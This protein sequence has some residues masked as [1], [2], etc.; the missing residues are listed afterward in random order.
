MISTKSICSRI[1]VTLAMLLVSFGLFAQN[2]TVK[3]TVTD[4]SGEPI[5]GAGVLVKGTSTGTTTDLDGKYSISVPQNATLVFSALGYDVVELSTKDRAVVNAAL[6]DSSE[7]LSE[8][9]VTAEFGMKRAARSVGSSVQSVKATDITEAGR[10][11]F[12]NALQGKV[13]GMTITSTGGA[14]GASTSVVLRSATSISGNNQPL[15]VVDGVPINNSTL[16]SQ[17]DFAYDDAVSA[18]SMDFSSRGNDINPEDIESM[19]IL[20]G[21]AAAALYGSDASNGAIIIT[22]KKGSAGRGKVTYSNSFRWENAYGLPDVQ[23]KYSNGAYGATNYYYTSRF[24]GLYPSDMKLYNNMQALLQTGFSQQHNLSVEGGTDKVTVRGALG[25]TDYDGIVKTTGLTRTNITLSGRAEVT[26]WLNFDGK[27]EY[28]QS[29]NTKSSKGLYG[30]LYRASRWPLNSDVQNYITPDGAMSRPELYTD[31]DLLNP[32]FDIYKNVNHDD[33]DRFMGSFNM[34]ITPTRHTFIRATAGVDF[35][36][37]EYKVFTHPYYGDP[38]SSSYGNGALNFSKPTYKDTSFDVLAG[39]NNNWGKFNF[40]AQV[41]YH[42]KA[43]DQHILSVYGSKFQVIDFYSISNC[44]PSTIQ[45]RTKTTTR[46]IQAV[47]AQAELG[48]NNM[49]FLT[50]RA[51]NDWSSTLPK[52]NN[53]YFYPAIEGSFV[54][55]ELPFLKNSDAISYLKLRGAIAQVGKDATPLSIYPSLEATEDWGGGFRYGYT[56]PNLA[57][58]P[59]MTTSYEIG[60]EGRFL[61]DRINTDFTYFWTKCENQYITG[62]RLSYATGFVL[63]NMNVGT[64]TTNGWEFHIDGD[65]LRLASGLR[66]NVGLNLDHST[67]CVTDLP[68][69]V[70]EYYNA[71]TWLSGNLRNGISVGNPITTIT[72]KGYMKNEK[73]DILIDPNTGLPIA[74]ADWSVLGDRQPKLAMGLQTSLSYKQFRLSASFSGRLGATVVNGTMRDMM[75]TGSSW[76]SVKL[77]ESEPVVFKGVLRDGKENSANPTV[78]TL[79]VDYGVFGTSIYTGCDEDWLER[80]VNYLRMNELRLSY[81]VPQ[82]WLQNA[83]KRLVSAAN[84]WVKGSDLF[85][86]TNYSGIDAVGNANS[87]ALGGTGGAGFDVWGI[88]TPRGYAL[89]I[90]LTF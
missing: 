31:T 44:D 69:N 42:Q 73:G 1:A 26:K 6:Q 20:K 8:A 58:K 81:T 67:S 25:Y 86:W 41:G 23:T 88:P 80:D 12:I 51:R 4:A 70:T 63:N 83:T 61:N 53:H 84:V 13:S 5:I 75:T 78:N 82:R 62:F 14:P 2:K 85:T 37:G 76:E 60:F 19:T 39:Y 54:A 18:Y 33:V 68:A 36:V 50:L 17:S 48:W 89:G 16:N 28:I 22:T 87:A 79:A 21:A 10:E 9:T 64:F 24:G 65:I 30:I 34:N 29:E 71:Y 15:Y 11:S 35:S 32:L 55:T 66:W 3:G 90:N 47:S 43:N 40:S 77:R 72:G 52:D 56:G 7:R 74:S 49:A 59:E 38:S 27:M 45:T 46:H 57:L